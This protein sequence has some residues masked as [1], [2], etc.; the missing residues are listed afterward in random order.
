M[1]RFEG[2]GGASL[3]VNPVIE[4]AEYGLCYHGNY[5]DETK[6]LVC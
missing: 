4:V 6:D 2:A 1:N 3:R 5:H